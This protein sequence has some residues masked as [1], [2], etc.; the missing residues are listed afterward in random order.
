MED[1][2]E[3]L[4]RYEHDKIPTG[5]FLRA[6]LENDLMGAIGKADI[7]NRHRLHDI[8][9]FVYNNLPSDIH[10]D[11]ERVAKHLRREAD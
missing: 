10:G 1:I 4:K 7:N 6:V 2:I 9:K 3:S 5:G 11:R 8:C